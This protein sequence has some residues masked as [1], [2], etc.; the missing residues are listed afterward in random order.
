MTEKQPSGHV[1]VIGAGVVGASTA[2]SLRRAGFEVTL[3]ERGEPGMGASYGNAGLLSATGTVPISTP[4]MLWQVPRLLLNPLAPLTIRWS[5]LPWLAPWL[6]RFVRAG[7]PRR[8][9]EISKVLAGLVAHG[10]DSYRALLGEDDFAEL[11]RGGGMLYVFETDQAFEGS[12]WK[13]DLRRSHGAEVN[14]VPPEQIR[15]LE[16]AL[17]PIYRH[18]L[19]VPG[20]RYVKDPLRLTQTIA[21]KLVEAGGRIVTDEVQ[22]IEASPGT[23]PV[24]VAKGG[25]HRADRIVIA[26]GAW[27]RALARQCG[28]DVPLDTE[29]GYHA[30]F[31]TPKIAARLSVMSGDYDFAAT[32]MEQGLRVA[33]TVELGGLAAAPNYARA[34]HLKR[35]GYRMFQGL[36]GAEAEF[37]MG[38]RPSMPDSLPV[39]G[40][41][42]G[43]DRV[44]LAFGHGHLG[45]TFGAVTGRLVTDLIAGRKPVVDPTP[46]RADRF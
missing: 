33:G 4:G 41:V 21:R 45:V 11:T 6:W 14:Y 34:E 43:N 23:A 38:F 7:S 42:P 15:Q 39:I 26:G 36:D 30:M 40:P 20:T 35:H 37:W 13:M 1:A 12:R 16:P 27:S 25:R 18:A 22:G 2:L 17:A 8:V 24:V 31:R 28:A 9:E 29:R 44:Y 10:Q 32:P 19:H 46:L 3:I 5:Y